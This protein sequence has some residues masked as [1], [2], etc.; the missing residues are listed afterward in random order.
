MNMIDGLTGRSQARLKAIYTRY[1]R[2]LPSSTEVAR[3]YR[4]VMDQID[5][6]I[7][8]EMLLAATLFAH[9]PAALRVHESADLDEHGGP[10][11]A[12]VITVSP[13]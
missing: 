6:L 7:G 11:G 4:Y 1:D 2:H 13:G 3:R 9:E 8:Y 12:L 10:L 5:G